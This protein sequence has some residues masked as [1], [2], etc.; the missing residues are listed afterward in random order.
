[1]LMSNRPIVVLIL[2]WNCQNSMSYYHLH[3]DSIDERNNS[4]TSIE[5]ST[6]EYTSVPNYQ[7]F[8]SNDTITSFFST[9]TVFITEV[10]LLFSIISLTIRTSRI[11]QQEYFYSVDILIN[12]TC[13]LKRESNVTLIFQSLSFNETKRC[14]FPPKHHGLMTCDNFTYGVHYT[15]DG[16]LLC[17]TRNVT[18]STRKELYESIKP[19]YINSTNS[20]TSIDTLFFLPGLFYRLIIELTSINQT[21]S[22]EYSS[23]YSPYYHCLFKNLIPAQWFVLTYYVS[24][25]NDQASSGDVTIVYTEL[26]DFYFRCELNKNNQQID[27]YWTNLI[28]SG[29]A[30]LTI[31]ILTEEYK[32]LGILSCDPYTSKSI[33]STKQY[34][35]ESGREYHIIAKLKKVLPNYNGQKTGTCSIKTNLSQISINSIRHEFLNETIVR[36]TWLNYPFHIQVRLRNL[37]TNILENPIE[38]N[39]RTAL[40]IHLTEA[41]IYQLE[42]NISKIH[43]SSLIQITDYYIQTDFKKLIIENIIRLSENTLIVNINRYDLSKI[44]IIYCIEQ[45]I[46]DSLKFCSIS[47]TFNQLIPGSIYNISVSIYRDSFENI[48]IWKKQTVYKLV[49]TN[50]SP[51][52]IRTWKG[53][54]Y[55][56]AELINT[57]SILHSIECI[58]N[59]KILNCNQ[60]QCGCR[61]R[62]HILFNQT[63][64]NS[65]CSKSQCDIQFNNSNFTNVHFQTPLESVKNL[66]LISHSLI[67]RKIQVDFDRP[68]GCFDRFILICETI[69]LKQRRI[70]I[71]STICTDLIPNEFYRIYVETKKIGWETVISNIIETRLDLTSNVNNEIT[72]KGSSLQSVII[73]CVIAILLILI[74]IVLIAFYFAYRY[75]RRKRMNQRDQQQITT[76]NNTNTTTKMNNVVNQVNIYSNSQQ[77]YPTE[78]K[79]NVLTSRP[80]QI[81]DL[82]FEYE[83]LIANNYYNISDEFHKLQNN[84]QQIPEF[85]QC[86]QSFKNR[87]KDIIPYE[88][89]RV[90]LIP[91]DECDSGYINANFISGLHNPR[92]YIACQGPLKSTINDHWKMIWEQNVRIIIMLSGLVERGMKNLFIENKQKR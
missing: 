27:F 87:Y 62:F 4:T 16:Y 64:I 79:K 56:A 2:L 31:S 14:L 61:Y 52:R 43:W 9:I 41:S 80:I 67:L 13:S 20:P 29:Y 22:I 88:H 71:N 8:T 92:E 74:L 36:L 19:K 6:I 73:P 89:S 46:D 75:N 1:M 45:M 5:S 54:E 15:V 57:Y 66:R 90:K 51:L 86:N 24:T 42:F 17:G 26:E 63:H 35:L 28:A 3:E 49:N 40:F 32:Q 37:E 25:D 39:Q 65:L 30:N 47:N 82:S 77:I 83:K 69:P 70:F 55:C 81:K 33:C 53:N 91:V 44:K 58:S 59:E 11:E 85:T 10:P 72:K 23:I 50:P 7:I 34:H 78:S 76:I 12:S 38:N 68:Y 48:F 84:L 18:L 21:C 60:L